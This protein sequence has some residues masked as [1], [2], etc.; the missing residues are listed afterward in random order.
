MLL[1]PGIHY[2]AHEATGFS[3]IGGNNGQNDASSQRENT[4]VMDL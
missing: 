4:R 3:L 1:G 2:L